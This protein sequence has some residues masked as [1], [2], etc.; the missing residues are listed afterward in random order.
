MAGFVGPGNW[1]GLPE[2]QLTE[3]LGGNRNSV[4]NARQNQY[5][6]DQFYNNLVGTGSG[7]T[8]I[9][10]TINNDQMIGPPIPTNT[11]QNLPNYGG[12]SGGS[13]EVLG[14]DSDLNKA[15]ND[16]YSPLLSGYNEQL[17]SLSK[18]LNLTRN[19]IQNA[20][21]QSAN[22]LGTN[23]TEGISQVKNQS[24]IAAQRKQDA[25]SA[26]VQLYNELLGGGRQRFGGASSAGEAYSA[27]SGR[28]L[29]KNQGTIQQGYGETMSQ[30]NQA[31]QGIQNQYATA[32]QN[33]ELQKTSALNDAMQ[34]YNDKVTQI[35]SDRNSTQSQKGMALYN[36]LL[37]LKNKS[38]NINNTI[39]QMSD[40]YNKQYQSSIATV[41]DAASKIGANVNTGRAA[42]TSFQGNTTTNPNTALN[43]TPSASPNTLVQTGSIRKNPWDDKNLLG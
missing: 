42:T 24:D 21:Q 29:M 7:E 25:L 19:N 5:N 23:R 30:L 26:A 33:L 40:A 38:Y 18:N 12:N 37:E 8:G 6:I 43:Y 3:A 28:E 39:S 9:D 11:N 16:I 20:Y 35:N 1:F 15:I 34:A 10:Y 17:G 32:M 14:A 2:L 31:A 41:Q 4:E 13:G 27:L 36:T 22:T